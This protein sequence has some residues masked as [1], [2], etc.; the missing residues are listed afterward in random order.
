VFI[1]YPL[2]TSTAEANLARSRLQYTQSQLELKNAELQVTAQVR[3]V[4]RQVTTNTR[5]VAA[6]RAASQL[7][8]KRLEAEQKKFA[9]GMSTSFLVFQAQRDLAQ[10]QSDELSSILDFSKSLVDFEAV[11]EAP[12]TGSSGT[13]SVAGSSS[14]TGAGSIGGTGGITG[15]AASSRSR[16]GQ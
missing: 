4:G 6:T 13:V 16:G 5:R 8:A 9:A 14:I 2:G 10:A 11:Q 15:T 12:V 1:S 7:A 3:D